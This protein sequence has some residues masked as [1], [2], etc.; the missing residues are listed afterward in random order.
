[1]AGG[2]K[3]KCVT[4]DPRWRDMVIKYRYNFTQAV[5]RYFWDVPLPPAAADHSV[6]AGNGE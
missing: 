3:I 1:M 6:S 4:S 5:S 2:R